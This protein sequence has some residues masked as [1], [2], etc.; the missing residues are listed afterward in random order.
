MKKIFVLILSLFLLSCNNIEN[1]STQK[2]NE[3]IVNNTLDNSITTQKNEDN[4]IQK[5]LR[6]SF[7]V[8]DPT[9]AKSPMVKYLKYPPSSILLFYENKLQIGFIQEF[10]TPEDNIPEN[11][12]YY[13]NEAIK[14]EPSCGKFSYFGYLTKISDNIYYSS[15]GI[16]TPTRNSYLKT[17]KNDIDFYIVIKNDKYYF[18]FEDLTLNEL[19]NFESDYYYIEN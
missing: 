6:Q 8:D 1:K 9:Y 19:K 10:E 2:V 17:I 7:V 14:C 15:K 11:I 18:V 12:K 3:N 5:V 13:K 4:L 16:I